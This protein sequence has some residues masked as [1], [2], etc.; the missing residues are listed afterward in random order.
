[1]RN[2]DPS[3]G[4]CNGTRL[5]CDRLTPYLITAT[6]AAGRFKGQQVLIPRIKLYPSENQPIRFT[7]TQFPVKLAYAMTINKSQGKT[8]QHVGIDLTSDT[9]AHGQLYVAL[10]RGTNVDDIHVLP[11]T[12][13]SSM[14]LQVGSH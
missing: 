3:K 2:L 10:S 14:Y 7:R 1:M 13:S 5:T 8:L 9:F 12:P 6:I 11:P 4:L